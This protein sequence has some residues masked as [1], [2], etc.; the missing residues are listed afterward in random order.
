VAPDSVPDP[1]R[2][3]EQRVGARLRAERELQGLSQHE[4]ARRLGVTFQQVQKYEKGQNRISSSRLIGFAEVLGI[5]PSR[6]LAESAR[7]ADV[8]PET[9]AHAQRLAHLFTTINNPRQR[10]ALLQMAESLADGAG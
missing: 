7:E 5:A 10:A 2:A 4:I 6:I 9:F 1:D 3:V 8:P